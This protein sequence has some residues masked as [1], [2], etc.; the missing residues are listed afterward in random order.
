[1]QFIPAYFPPIAYIVQLINNDVI[2]SLGGNYQKQTY[3]NRST[4]YGANGK[5]NLTVPIIH[6]GERGDLNIK[7]SAAND[8]KNQHWKSFSSAYRSSP[9]FEFYE[10]ELREEF[11]TDEPY[12]AKFNIKLIA[13]IMQWLD[14]PFDFSVEEKYMPLTEEEGFYI[15]AKVEPKISLPPYNQVFE[16][17]HGFLPHLSVLDLIFNLGPQSRDYLLSIAEL[18]PSK[19]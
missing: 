4:I 7:I 6:D 16:T 14:F 15:N 12:L 19:A 11:F 13:L 9:F 2:F 8:W 1:M 3:R 10:D 17:K 18:L 5:L